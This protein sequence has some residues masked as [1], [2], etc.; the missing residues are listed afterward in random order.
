[1]AY[2]MSGWRPNWGKKRLETGDV[3]FNGEYHQ[4]GTKR[5]LG[6]KY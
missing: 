2:V 5:I 6:K 4:P 3:H 1:M